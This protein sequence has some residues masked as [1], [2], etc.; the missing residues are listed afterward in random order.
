[1]YFYEISAALGIFFQCRSPLFSLP[2]K[3]NSYHSSPFTRRIYNVAQVIAW[4]CQFVLSHLGLA[5]M[6]SISCDNCCPP[7]TGIY[8][9]SEITFA[10]V[11]RLQ[12]NC[13]LSMCFF[14]SI[15]RHAPYFF[16]RTF[17]GK[18]KAAHCSSVASMSNAVYSL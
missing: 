5:H 10:D 13:S 1:M 18:L 3:K 15:V 8:A 4:L 11:N 6:A 12:A 16:V 7:G 9:R 14:R 17:T 2:T